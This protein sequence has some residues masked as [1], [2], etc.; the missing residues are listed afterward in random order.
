LHGFLCGKSKPKPYG[1]TYMKEIWR[2]STIW[3]RLILALGAIPIAL[4]V[5]VFWAGFSANNAN[6]IKRRM[7]YST[8]R[9]TDVTDGQKLL[10][11]LQTGEDHMLRVAQSPYVRTMTY[12]RVFGDYTLEETRLSGGQQVMAI[13]I[14]IANDT[15]YMLILVAP[16]AWLTVRRAKRIDQSRRKA[17]RV[18]WVIVWPFISFVVL[19]LTPMAV[20][21]IPFRWWFPPLN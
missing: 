21:A 9:L 6:D 5:L 3:G 7:D 15:L 13:V 8:G 14:T 20:Y 17:S 1:G 11:S 18:A 4:M 12:A 19:F 2:T 10:W 16:T